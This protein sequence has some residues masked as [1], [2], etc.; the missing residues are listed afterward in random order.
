MQTLKINLN[1]MRT[2]LFNLIFCLV[3]HGIS[4][5]QNKSYKAPL[6][7]SIIF[8]DNTSIAFTS[9]PKK[10]SSLFSIVGISSKTSE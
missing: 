2:L 3:F 8:N 4:H 9:K 1:L 7:K 10:L 6:T 5:S